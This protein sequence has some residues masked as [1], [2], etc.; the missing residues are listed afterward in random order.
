MTI[1]IYN[2]E[3]HNLIICDDTV[4][5]I[6]LNI[7][8]FDDVKN[9]LGNKKIM[10]VT[11]YIET[12]VDSICDM[13]IN[14]DMEQDVVGD[15]NNVIS[16]KQYIH[17]T[18]KTKFY[19]QHG[20]AQ[21]IFHGLYDCKN[22]DDFPQNFLTDCKDIV[23]GLRI[24]LLE[25]IGE[26]Q[27]QELMLQKAK[28]PARRSKQTIIKDLSTASNEDGEKGSIDNPIQIDLSGSGNFKRNKT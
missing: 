21:Y 28:E 7:Q 19:A 24:G 10:Y 5:Y 13:F 8:T 1:V 27:V 23:E 22:I 16:K 11:E 15:V 26:H 6:D 25:I 14:Q 20:G 4:Q 2:P 18:N 12:D 3:T 9:Y 17:L